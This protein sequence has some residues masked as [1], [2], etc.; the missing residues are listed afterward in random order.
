MV[1]HGKPK[2]NLRVG[3]VCT[4]QMEHRRTYFLRQLRPISQALNTYRLAM[5]LK[6]LLGVLEWHGWHGW[7]GWHSLETSF[8]H[9]RRDGEVMVTTMKVPLLRKEGCMCG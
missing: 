4:P 6:P 1:S 7:H 2:N 5:F 8:V 9:A 3:V